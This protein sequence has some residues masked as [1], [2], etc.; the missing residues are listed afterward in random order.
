MALGHK[1]WPILLCP[2]PPPH[3]TPPP[4]HDPVA[5]FTTDSSSW[6]LVTLWPILLCPQKMIL[7]LG[8]LQIPQAG[9]WS[10]C[11]L[12]Y[13]PPPPPPPPPQM[14]LL[15]CGPYYTPRK[16]FVTRFST[17]FPRWPLVTIRP[18]LCP[19]KWSCYSVQTQFLRVSSNS[20]RCP[21][22]IMW[23]ILYP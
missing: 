10:Q 6:P 15:Q 23:P 11:G 12:F 5:R 8:L 19:R 9:P 17:G 20:Y 3:P 2:P 16:W 7:L 1:M 14:I 18:V 13:S 22:V 21:L 4:P